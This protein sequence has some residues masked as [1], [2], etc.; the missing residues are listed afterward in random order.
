MHIV[1]IGAGPAGCFCAVESARHNPG[2]KVSV[3]EASSRPMAKLAL[4]GGGRCNITNTFA[5]VDNLGRVYPRGWKLMRKALGTFSHEDLLRWFE[6]QG[7]R[8]VEEAGGRVFPASQDAMQ[9]VRTLER[10]MREC[11]VAVECRKR[12]VK[13]E[14]AAGG[15]ALHFPD[16]SC[17]AADRVVLATGGTSE[18][19]LRALLPDSVETVPTVPSLFTF[20]IEDSALRSLMGTVAGNAVVSLAGT[21]FREQGALL[22]TDW[23][24]SG[25]AILSLSSYA[26]VH[27][28]ECGYRATL[29]VNWC[30]LTE[31]EIMDWIERTVEA[32]PARLV[33]GVGPEGMASRLWKHLLRRCALREDLR[34]AE[35]GAKGKRRLAAILASDSYE[36]TGRAAFREEFVTCGGV[37]LKSVNPSTMEC[38]SVPGLYFAGEVLDI[39]G[40]TGGFNLQAAWSTA[41]CAG[42]G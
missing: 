42:K 24:V 6:A 13:I 4:T 12:V 31:T 1:I 14:V 23:G 39:D 5:G 26:A 20:R 28:A 2:A 19:K 37:S 17:V 33:S 38:R 11:S 15:F 29:L 30:G 9:I 8:F 27:L 10:L 36:I 32:A 3:Y 34:W 18:A 25:P 7:V 35:L 21:R 16:G 22:I 40:V 41:Y